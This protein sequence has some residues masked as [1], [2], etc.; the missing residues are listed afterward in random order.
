METKFGLWPTNFIRLILFA[1]IRW[2]RGQKSVL[3]LKN[4]FYFANASNSAHDENAPCGLMPLA[5]WPITRTP[6][7]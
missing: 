6:M 3:G 2:I 5:G 7:A 4:A 1:F